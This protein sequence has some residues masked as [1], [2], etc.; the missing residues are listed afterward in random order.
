MNQFKPRHYFCCWKDDEPRG[1]YQIDSEL[2]HP[3][4]KRPTLPEAILRLAQAEYEAQCGSRQ[5]YERMQQRQGLSILEVVRLLADY[6]ER[7]GGEPTKPRTNR[8]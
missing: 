7:L 1:V 3:I 8:D 4:G 2:R 5:D 6:V